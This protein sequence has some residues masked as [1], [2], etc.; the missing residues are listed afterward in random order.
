MAMCLFTTGC[1]LSC[2][3]G[4]LDQSSIYPLA[5]N[6]GPYSLDMLYL[7]LRFHIILYIMKYPICL[8][9]TPQTSA[10]FL[11]CGVVGNHVEICNDTRWVAPELVFLA[12][13]PDLFEGILRCQ[14]KLMPLDTKLLWQNLPEIHQNTALKVPF[15]DVLFAAG[16]IGTRQQ[17]HGAIPTTGSIGLLYMKRF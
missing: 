16:L 5:I 4:S 10:V 15:G 9:F 8:H 2:V 14:L 6:E 17:Q 3:D 12:G 13:R 11:Q 1:I 7:C